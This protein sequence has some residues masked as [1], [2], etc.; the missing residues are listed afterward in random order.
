MWDRKANT[1]TLGLGGGVDELA[2]E[3][4]PVLVVRGL[5]DDDL[6]V[7]VGQLVDNVL[8]L[9]VELQVVEGRY[10]L[11][12]DGGSVVQEESAQTLICFAKVPGPGLFIVCR[13]VGWC[14]W[15]SSKTKGITGTR[16]EE[17]TAICWRGK[18]GRRTLIETTGQ[19]N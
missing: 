12:R 18:V 19:Q 1:Y 15:G 6:T 11:L 8:V 3:V 17:R 13:E 16:Q 10:A 9:L 7:V 4:L 14:W 2:A 5:L